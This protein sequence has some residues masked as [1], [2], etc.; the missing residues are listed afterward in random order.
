MANVSGRCLFSESD[1]APIKDTCR[2]LI[3]KRQRQVRSYAQGDQYHLPCRPLSKL[4]RKKKGQDESKNNNSQPQAQ[5]L[6]YRQTGII[7]A[8]RTRPAKIPVIHTR[9]SGSDVG[10]VGSYGSMLPPHAQSRCTRRILPEDCPRIKATPS[11]RSARDMLRLSRRR[12][13]AWRP[14]QASGMY[15]APGRY[16]LGGVAERHNMDLARRRV[17]YHPRHRLQPS[18]VVLAKNVVATRAGSGYISSGHDL[19]S[20]CAPGHVAQSTK[21]RMSQCHMNVREARTFSGRNR[22]DANR[23]LR[24][25]LSTSAG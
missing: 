25:L 5:W 19:I 10:G 16:Q 8:A 22:G 7:A 17:V 11:K 9:R 24:C 12:V 4:R 13:R 1:L 21:T 3:V 15:E 18:I 14:A 20:A 6:Q 2:S 23:G